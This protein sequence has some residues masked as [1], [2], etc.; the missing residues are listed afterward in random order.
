[1][2]DEGKR[3]K[4]S[5][6]WENRSPGRFWNR[7]S[8]KLHGSILCL[9]STSKMHETDILSSS[10]PVALA[11][12]ET[13]GHFKPFGPLWEAFH[14][15]ATQ[16]KPVLYKK[17]TSKFQNRDLCHCI[18]LYFRWCVLA[19]EGSQTISY[20]YIYIIHIWA[21]DTIIVVLVQ[22]C[23]ALALPVGVC[24]SFITDRGRPHTDT[25]FC[26]SHLK[27]WECKHPHYR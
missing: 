25:L 11:S 17:R 19:F 26:M 20:I 16:L 7:H 8:D 23:F 24:K 10:F 14:E 3:H 5:L 21:T 4:F 9:W 12:L 15:R 2:L 13:F 27:V 6:H 1:M 22:S 18:N